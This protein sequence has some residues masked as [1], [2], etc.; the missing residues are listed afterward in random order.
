VIFT[1][2]KLRDAYIVEIERREDD[3]GFFARSWCQREFAEQRM[4]SALAQVN[5]SFSRK[6][7]TLR[8][9]HYQMKPYEE[10]KLLR[11]TRGAIYDVIIDLRPNSTTYGQWVGVDLTADNY[12]MVFVPEGFAHGFE[13]LSDN[14]EV[15][16]QVSQFFTPE[17]ERGIR[18]N[19]PAFGIQWPVKVE[20]ISAK[21]ASWPDYSPNAHAMAS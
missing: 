6:R 15:T 21:D 7:G 20:V 8:G 2:T 19:D 10:T 17:A 18:Y 16:Y 4:V 9:M 1:P 3:R 13:T 11:C 12:K 14:A 5:V